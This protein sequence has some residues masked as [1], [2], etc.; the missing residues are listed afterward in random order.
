[1]GNVVE[2]LTFDKLS[3]GC[4]C[5]CLDA[6]HYIDMRTG[7]ICEYQHNENRAASMASIRRTLARIRELVNTNVTVPERCL[8]VTLTYADNMTDTVQ[9][10]EDF[11][12]FWMR[13]KYQCKRMGYSIPEYITVQE[14]QGRGAWHIHAFFI[15]DTKA[16]FIPNNKDVMERM[17]QIPKGTKTLADMW[18]HG[19]T[20]TQALGDCDNIGAY[21]SA[22][23]ADMPIEELQKLPAE[24]F[25]KITGQQKVVESTDDQGE[26]QEKRFIKGARLVLYPTNM[27]IVRKSK[28]IKEPMVERMTLGEAQKKVSA[29]TKTFSRS[30]AIVGDDGEIVQTISK[31]YYNKVRKSPQR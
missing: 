29:A 11:R 22:Y 16:P 30:Y 27:Q 6:D 23:L 9:L 20:K 5:K 14:P 1:M 26:K 2:L 12:R 10:Y 7:E 18:G 24:Q 28:G 31:A 15:W 4:P 3:T 19:Y 8:W 25:V 13:F 17:K 21:F